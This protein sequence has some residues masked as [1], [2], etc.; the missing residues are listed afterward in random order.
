MLNRN[1]P[2]AA[3]RSAVGEALLLRGRYAESER[4]LLD[5]L[6]TLRKERGEDQELTRLARARLVMLY[7]RWGKPG[8]AAKYR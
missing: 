3:S 2:S 8:E 1:A 4:L 7:D 6:A 5:A